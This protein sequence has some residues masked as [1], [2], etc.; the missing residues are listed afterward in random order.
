MDVWYVAYGSNT[1]RERLGRYLAACRDPAAPRESRAVEL[2][3][4]LYFATES[5]VWGGGRGFHDPGAAGRTLARAHLLTAEQFGDITALEMYREPGDGAGFGAGFGAGELA[6]VVARGCVSFGSGRYETVVCA[7]ELD[8]LPMLTFT[9]PWAVADVE[10]RA[11]AEPYLRHIAAGLQES[12]A[13]TDREIARYLAGSPGAAGTWTEEDVLSFLTI[14][15]DNPR[16][17]GSHTFG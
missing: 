14:L 8:G 4:V 7:G 5:A 11:P 9:A 3:G 6:E 1:H 12:G 2:D 15:P 16:S 17:G 13:W 10:L